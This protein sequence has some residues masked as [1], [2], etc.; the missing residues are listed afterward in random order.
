MNKRI[1]KLLLSNCGSFK[2]LNPRKKAI[3]ILLLLSL[4]FSNQINAQTSDTTNLF[5]KEIVNA[6]KS[7]DFLV[8]KRLLLTSEEFA[9][10][11][12]P[13]VQKDT[14]YRIPD[15]MIQ[16]GIQFYKDGKLEKLNAKLF[17]DI[18]KD[19]RTLGLLSW[20]DAKYISFGTQG[21]IF[22]QRDPRLV[23]GNLVFSCQGKLYEL[24]GVY[25][26]KLNNAI[27]LILI[28]GIRVLV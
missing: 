20:D 17:D 1:L 7:N 14:A 5:V 28:R 26:V 19:A 12:A 3:R 21:R 18:L 2:Y 25:G 11:V 8:Y 10:E 9:N 22:V 23:M 24:Y 16:E 6:F 4:F 15:F 13:I 27:K